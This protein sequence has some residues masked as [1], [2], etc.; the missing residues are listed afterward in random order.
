[1][2]LCQSRNSQCEPHSSPRQLP[3]LANATPAINGTANGA[4][5]TAERVLLVDLRRPRRL[6]TLQ[7]LR[8]ALLQKDRLHLRRSD[9]A[10]AR[11]WLPPCTPRRRDLRRWRCFGCSCRLRRLVALPLIGLPGGRWG[12]HSVHSS[13]SGGDRGGGRFT[14]CRIRCSRLLVAKESGRGRHRRSESEQRGEKQHELSCPAH[15]G[16]ALRRRSTAIPYPEPV[17]WTWEKCEARVPPVTAFQLPFQLPQ[18]PS[19]E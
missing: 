13:C 7:E 12:S 14:T 9:L 15:G 16:T 4:D 5:L 17:T 18:I 19:G 8:P 11:L 10:S 2:E 3:A 6:R 1:M